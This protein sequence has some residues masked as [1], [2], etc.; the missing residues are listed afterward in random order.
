VAGTTTR[1]VLDG[2]RQLTNVLAETTGAGTVT[3]S[4]VY[5]LGLVV[6]VLPDG[7]ELTY[8][9]DSRGSAIA[10]TDA[11]A[12]TTDQYAYGP[13]GQVVNRTG[14]TANSF[15]YLGRHGI[16]DDGNGLNYAR[17]R[18]YAAA[19]GRFL[20]KDPLT[21]NERDG[22]SLHRYIYAMNNPVRLID[23]SG[24]SA[25]E[26]TLYRNTYGSSDAAHAQILNPSTMLSGL[27][28]SNWWQFLELLKD[29]GDV[30]QTL[31]KLREWWDQRSYGS[32][33][34]GLASDA[35]ALYQ[36]RE[37]IKTEVQNGQI[38]KE[39]ATSLEA[40]HDLLN[41]GIGYNPSAT[42]ADWLTGGQ[43]SK[44]TKKIIDA[45]ADPIG[46]EC[47]RAGI[48]AAECESYR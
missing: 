41:L 16:T 43:I 34:L 19:T 5:G 9:Y 47:Q 24:L 45:I 17:V 32:N 27:S 25:R 13:F 6:R 42:F 20:T 26:G 2:N 39:N 33:V 1:Y 38:R 28:A 37:Q 48:S 30:A 44:N 4:Y 40:A 46:N 35:V 7:S 11:T 29:S 10:L 23:I 36:E 3:A 8:H 15:A 18:Y 22:Q 31:I 12:T 21:G 14:I